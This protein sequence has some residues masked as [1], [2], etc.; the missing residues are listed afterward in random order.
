MILSNY[1][2]M[3]DNII[4]TIEPIQ[5]QEVIQEQKQ[6]T[7]PPQKKNMK[8]VFGFITALTLLNLLLL[9]ALGGFTFYQSRQLASTS[10]QL[11][12]INQQLGIV[13]DAG[14][15]QAESST[16]IQNKLNNINTTPKTGTGTIVPGNVTSFN[17][18]SKSIVKIYNIS[19][20]QTVSGTGTIID[21]QG[22]ILTNMHVIENTSSYY[23]TSTSSIL[24]ICITGNTEEKPACNYTAEV[25]GV[26]DEVVDLAL[27][28]I[29]KK[30]NYTNNKFTTTELSSTDLSSLKAKNI[31]FDNNVKPDLGAQINVLGYPGAG[32]DNISLTQGIYS[33]SLDETY[34][35]TDAKV[36]SGNSG[37]AAFDKDD[38]F[39]GVPTAVSGG[40][41]N[42]GL[43]IKAQ[44]VIDFVKENIS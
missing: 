5:N 16:E 25:V 27:L 31:L 22:H 11:K 12:K 19:R 9:L 3:E 43:I 35:K 29:N 36:N 1:K 15:K 8:K 40:Q 28:K 14:T 34:F 4:Q 21:N 41:G 18:L 6:Y 44:A 26:G 42:I 17:N 39:L 7:I 30:L 2:F 10:E 32:G 33:G 24:A 38:K 23:N 13:K 37:G 20:S